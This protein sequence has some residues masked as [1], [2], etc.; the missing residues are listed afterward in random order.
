MI[1]ERAAPRIPERSV[2]HQVKWRD[3]AVFGGRLRS[4]LE[5]PE[6]PLSQGEQADW[7]FRVLASPPP[8]VP[9]EPIGERQ[10][11]SEWYRLART[12]TGLRLE[13]SHAGCFDIS[14]DGTAIVWYHRAD[15]TLE[16]V[17]T[18]LLGSVFALALEL[19]GVLC[20]HA[21]AVAIGTRAVAFVGPKH[22]GKST[23]AAA[24]TSSGAKLIGDDLLPISLGPPAMVR[25][26]VA[27][28]RLWEDTLRA[29]AVDTLCKRVIPGVKT[30]ATGFSDR[31]LFQGIAPLDAVYVLAPVGPGAVIGAA[32]RER[33]PGVAGAIMLARHTKLP[34][35]LVGL[36]AAGAQLAAAATVMATVPL[37]SLRVV[38][39]FACLPALVQQILDWH[40]EKRP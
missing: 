27:S 31:L 29:L 23:I 36:R 38:R 3:Y 30:T 2:T 20:L 32:Q 24:L 8:P 25:P 13:Y 15:A 39:D 5:L 22:H 4:E 28:V 16:L 35:S 1:A 40:Q 10:L 14:S 11:D 19:G 12:P 7:I 37:Y 21:S 34:G 18:I 33:I 17:R 26:A 6:L 9:L